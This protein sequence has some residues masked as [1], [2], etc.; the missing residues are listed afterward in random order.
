VPT[1]A[2][3]IANRRSVE[4]H[5]TCPR[6]VVDEELWRLL[7]ARLA[8]GR[9][10]LLGLWG[11]VAAVHMAILD[12]SQAYIFVATIECPDG[13][14][15]SVGRLHPPRFGLNARSGISSALIP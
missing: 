3:L 10:T 7:A 12:D 14:F 13:H 9:G 5:R 1:L 8:D 6:V 2:E 15:P 11:D 4:W